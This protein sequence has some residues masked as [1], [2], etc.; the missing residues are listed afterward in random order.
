MPSWSD[1]TVVA[2]PAS[3][4]DE[5][6]RASHRRRAGPACGGVR[7]HRGAVGCP[8]RR[9]GLH[10]AARRAG[11][12]SSD[13]R[14]AGASL[15]SAGSRTGWDA[16]AAISCCSWVSRSRARP[17]P[18]ARFWV[19]I[20]VALDRVC[21]HR[22]VDNWSGD[23]ARTDDARQR[24]HRRGREGRCSGVRVV[25][26]GRLLVRGRRCSAATVPD[27]LGTS[28]ASAWPFLVLVPSVWPAPSSP[29]GCL[30]RSRPTAAGNRPGPR[31]RHGAGTGWDLPDPRPPA[32]D[33][34]RG[35]CGRRG[36]GD[37]ELPCL[38]P[39]RALRRAGR[40]ARRAVLRHVAAASRLRLAGAAA[41]GPGGAGTDDGGHPPAEQCAAR[42][43][44]AFAPTFPVAV[45][46]LLARTSLSQMD[47]PTR[48]ALVM[49]VVEPSERTAAAAVTN[50][51]RYTVRPFGPLIGGLLNRSRWDCR[52][53]WPGS[54]KAAMTSALWRWSGRLPRS[55]TD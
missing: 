7:P 31:R 11:A 30:R 32:G 18:P 24:R 9:A 14:T 38:L 13:R 22:L 19:L 46:L 28:P 55:N 21:C 23:H 41:G 2:L 35:G 12:G 1:A 53:S 29:H 27:R 49:S 33:V 36:S 26:R 34:V 42:A 50:T 17:S 16:A 39:H 20:V 44:V 45:I 37:R 25:Q 10:A 4:Q 48:Q 52:W 51:A 15:S 54:S 8:A 43:S 40:P 6:G 47:V 5:P 3:S